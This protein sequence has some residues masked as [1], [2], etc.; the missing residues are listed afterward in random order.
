MSEVAFEVTRTRA[1]MFKGIFAHLLRSPST[2]SWYIGGA[3]VVAVVVVVVN[4]GEATS[5]LAMTFGVTFVVMMAVFL[6][7]ALASIYFAARKSWMAP[8]ALQ[9][10]KFVLSAEGLQ[11]TA[12]TASGRSGWDNWKGAFETR[13][14]IVIRHSL[15]LLQ[16]IP[17]KALPAQTA[18]AIRALLIANL[19]G[20]VWLSREKQR[21]P[22]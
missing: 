21:T 20:G 5:N 22:K 12:G 7:T 19:K 4:G 16:I 8:G 10:I 18:S 6:L 3:L 1:D 15:G 17:T 13:S 9:P 2:W 14:L 11:A